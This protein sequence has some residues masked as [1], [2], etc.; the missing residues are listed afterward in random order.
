MHGQS[1]RIGVA[2]YNNVGQRSS[3]VFSPPIQID[4]TP[5]EEVRGVRIK[6]NIY[7]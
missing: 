6:H 2:C 5:P 3:D 7:S 4:N 1:Y